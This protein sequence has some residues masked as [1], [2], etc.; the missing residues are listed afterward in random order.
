M[1]GWALEML[2]VRVPVISS[3]FGF[4]VANLGMALGVIKGLA[5]RAPRGYQMPVESGQEN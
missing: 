1:I 5:G 3:L 2:H 4:A